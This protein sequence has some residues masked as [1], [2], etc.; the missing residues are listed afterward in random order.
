MAQHEYCSFLCKDLDG[1][2]DFP[3]QLRFLHCLVSSS[4]KPF[5]NT[6]AMPL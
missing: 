6:A 3:L 4:Q 5:P 1:N 2:F